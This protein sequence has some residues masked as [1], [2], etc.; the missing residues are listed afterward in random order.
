[1]VVLRLNV[2]ERTIVTPF[3][4]AQFTIHLLVR[5][6]PQFVV[7]VGDEVV[8]NPSLRELVGLEAILHRDAVL[9]GIGA[10]GALVEVVVVVGN[11]LND[12]TEVVAFCVVVALTVSRVRL[13]DQQGIVVVMGKSRCLPCEDVMSAMSTIASDHGRSS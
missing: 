6:I 1:M 5:L 3:I 7:N 9:H 10:S 2:A 11:L 12:C 13:N 8:D 4:D